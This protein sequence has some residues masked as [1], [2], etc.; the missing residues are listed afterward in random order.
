[1]KTIRSLL[2]ALFA[3]SLFSACTAQDK[4]KE[5][6]QK[7]SEPEGVELV[8]FHFTSRC[9]TCR[10]VEA[11]ASEAV[12]ENYIGVVEFNAYNIDNADGEKRGRE[13]GVNGQALLLVYG[14]QK[15]NLTNEGFMYA[16]TNPEKFKEVIKAKIDPILK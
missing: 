5:E 7:I 12:A 11:V 16:R 15:I 4:N 3:L 9:V 8:Y 2:L 14:D 6:V 1:M 13:L 10:S